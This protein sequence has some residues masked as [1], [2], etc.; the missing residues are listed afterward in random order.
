MQVLDPSWEGSPPRLSPA[1]RLIALA[2]VDVALLSNGK[3]GVAPLFDH[4]ESLLRQRWNVATVERA[5]KGNYSAPAE[6]E[7][8][9]R[10]AR[11][12]LVITGVGD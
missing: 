10:L 11:R 2:G 5:T 12:R 1:P 9:R 7:L 4:L 6:P 8:V 3:A